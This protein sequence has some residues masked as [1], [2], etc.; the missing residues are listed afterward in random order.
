MK[1]RLKKVLT[2]VMI[3]MLLC[4]L[5][6]CSKPMPSADDPAASDRVIARDKPTIPENAAEGIDSLYDFRFS[7]RYGDR[8]SGNFSLILPEGTGFHRDR[9]CLLEKYENKT[10]PVSVYSYDGEGMAPHMYKRYWYTFETGGSLLV[11]T[12]FYEPDS[13]EYVSYFWT[14]AEGAKTNQGIGVGSTETALLS[15]YTEDLYYLDLDD[16]EPAMVK[17]A[18][19]HD[20]GF[21]F[22]HAYAWQPFTTENNDIRDITFYIKDGKVSSI[23]VAEP[24]ELRYVYAVCQ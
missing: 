4:V 11:E 18:E 3:V 10:P 19:D 9:L 13:V 15:A 20:A 14:D 17:Y 6:A 5:A 23:E 12:D 2:G 8:V 1:V 24:F 16:A 22:D 7:E 21:E